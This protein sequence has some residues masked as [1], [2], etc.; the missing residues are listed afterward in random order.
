MAAAKPARKNKIPKLLL[1]DVAVK[2]SFIGKA[3]TVGDAW[4]GN[5]GVKYEF[6]DRLQPKCNMKDTILTKHLN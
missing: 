6:P 5:R 2:S 1:P 3:S 4:R